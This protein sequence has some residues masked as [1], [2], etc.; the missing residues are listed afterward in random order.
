LGIDGWWLDGGEGPPAG[1]ALAAGPATQLHNRY[2]LMR[3]QAFA[4]GEAENRPDRRPWLLCRS[5]GPGMQRY[6]AVPWSGDINTTFAI[7][8]SQIRI[9]LNCGMSGIPHWG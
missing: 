6:G 9:G 2:D 4:E 7:L 5:G 1:T 3:Q 8:E